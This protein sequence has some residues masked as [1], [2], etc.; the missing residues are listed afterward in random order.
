MQYLLRLRRSVG[1]QQQNQPDDVLRVKTA[2]NQLG[3]YDIGKHGLG[4][5]ADDALASAIREYQRQRGLKVDGQMRPGGPTEQDIESVLQDPG[6]DIAARTPTY[7]C[8][9]CGAP[10]GGLHGPICHRCWDRLNS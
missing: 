1:H 8:I 5:G 3:Y 2:L 6:F 4:G 7:R 10:H 9:I